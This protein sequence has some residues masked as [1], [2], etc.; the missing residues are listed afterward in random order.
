M[1]VCKISVNQGC[2]L[3]NFYT[4]PFT[5]PWIAVYKI[6]DINHLSLNQRAAFIKINLSHKVFINNHLLLLL[7]SSNEVN[8]YICTI[9]FYRN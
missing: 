9:H 3:F 4:Y 6:T 8:I 5:C 7:F 1:Q 2:G